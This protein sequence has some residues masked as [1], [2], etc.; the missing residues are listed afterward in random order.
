MGASALK[1]CYIVIHGQVRSDWPVHKI[2]QW[3]DHLGGVASFKSKITEET[4]HL[5]VP[6]K[7]WQ[8]RG[9]FVQ[10]VLE[11]TENGHDI[12]IVSSE[13][14]EDCLNNRAK[15]SESRYLWANLDMRSMKLNDQQA[16]QSSKLAKQPGNIQGLMAQ[17][18]LQTTE[19][20]ITDSDRKKIAQQQEK[21]AQ[22]QE[23]ADNEAR[24][25][26]KDHRERMSIPE[27]AAVFRRGAKR[28]RNEILSDN[29]HIYVDNTN[30]TFDVTVTKVDL[31]QNTNERYV[32]TLQIY[33]S[34]NEPSTY[35]FN[36]QFA[37]TR[38]LPQ[39]DIIVAIGANFP[40]VFRAFKK[41]F[42]EKTKIEWDNRMSQTWDRARQAADGKVA[43]RP[44]EVRFEDAPFVYHP[45]LYGPKG[46]L[47]AGKQ[48]EVV[49]LADTPGPDLRM[50]GA[51]GG[52]PTSS[53]SSS[54]GKSRK[55]P[56]PKVSD[57]ELAA[58]EEPENDPL[59]YPFEG[60]S[61]SAL[62]LDQS[63]GLEG[64][65]FEANQGGSDAMGGQ[66]SSLG[67]GFLDDQQP[68]SY[69]STTYD[70]PY[71][72][73]GATSQVESTMDAAPVNNFNP[74]YDQV[75]NST[76]GGDEKFD[77]EEY[78]NMDQFETQG[79][80]N[81]NYTQA[82]N[83]AGN[84]LMQMIQQNPV[85]SSASSVLGKRKDSGGMDQGAKR[86]RLDN[87]PGEASDGASQDKSMQRY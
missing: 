16:K 55:H 59:S 12:L 61:D 63:L 69:R 43:R 51:I 11:A 83:M 62:D 70:N 54:R 72:P 42:L 56:G 76:N 86:A 77:F 34:N 15:R 25:Q 53:G 9:P 60:S 3:V 2:K 21:E 37:G 84:N 68:N 44:A 36:C 41:V 58:I 30:F 80:Q 74:G 35:A 73:V 26:F 57:M 22:A 5:V 6:E 38:I 81:A 8:S 1:G 78:L 4:T 10:E 33:E 48:S 75:I 50:S 23:E 47:P 29:H 27:Q 45:P 24:L 20:H 85:A 82:A 79:T 49:N 39:N 32:L 18:F 66:D 64:A 87:L 65:D 14:L 40:T 71:Q 19:A 52:S 46:D 13:W 7:E 17:T 67:A 28:A 31:K